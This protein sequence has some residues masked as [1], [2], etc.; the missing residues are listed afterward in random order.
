MLLRVNPVPSVCVNVVSESAP[1]DNTALSEIS[2]RS[3]PTDKSAAIP[4]PPAT[5]NAPSL[6]LVFAVVAE[7][8]TT[9]PEDIEIASVSDADPML[10]ASGITIFPPVVIRP[11]PVYVPDT[12]RFALMSASVAFISTSS[13]AFISRTVPEGAVMF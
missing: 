3:S 13:V 8:F 11:P 5:V 12:S 9:P 2:L 10:P 1:K 4:A 6:A 7:I